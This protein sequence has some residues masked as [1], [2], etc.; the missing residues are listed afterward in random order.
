[1]QALA[2]ASCEDWKTTLSHDNFS[3]GLKRLHVIDK[4]VLAEAGLKFQPWG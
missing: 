4:I 2:G 1:M 3:P